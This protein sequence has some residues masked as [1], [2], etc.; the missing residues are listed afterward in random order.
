MRY[1]GVV[2]L[3][4][5]FAALVA[6]LVT[7]NLRPR[8]L[9]DKKPLV[10]IGQASYAAYLLHLIFLNGAE[11]VLPESLAGDVGALIIGG[12]ATFAVSI[13]VQRYFEGPITLSGHRLADRLFPRRPARDLLDPLDVRERSRQLAED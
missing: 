3:F 8:T 10:V 12:A 2:L 13:A 11:K 5:G 7:T 9:L 1:L 6:G 4:P